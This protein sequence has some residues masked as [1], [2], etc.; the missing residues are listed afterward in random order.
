MIWAIRAVL[1]P[2]YL[3]NVPQYEPPHTQNNLSCTISALVECEYIVK[4]PDFERRDFQELWDEYYKE[5]DVPHV[6]SALERAE[7]TGRIRSRGYISRR[8]A[9]RKLEKGEPVMLWIND[10]YR[11]N[12]ILKKRTNTRSSWHAV[13]AVWHIEVEWQSYFIIR[14]TR[15]E[16]WLN[17]YF[18]VENEVVTRFFSFKTKNQ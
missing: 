11:D 15:G 18:I 17:G 9:K 2:R 5:W 10:Y 6:R 4:W 1:Y 14:N 7:D 8:E 16:E 12:W 3:T 13:C